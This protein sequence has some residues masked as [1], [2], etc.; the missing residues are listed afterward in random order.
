MTTKD[1]TLP[2]M[3]RVQRSLARDLIDAF[4]RD[5]IAGVYARAALAVPKLFPPKPKPT[6]TD[7]DKATDLLSDAYLLAT[8]RH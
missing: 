6:A 7:L 2:S 3:E 1:Y 8:E 5:G 4:D